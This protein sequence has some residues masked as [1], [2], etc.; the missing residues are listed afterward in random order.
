MSDIGRYEREFVNTLAEA[1]YGAMRCPAS[2]GGVDRELPD[3]LV[4]R[5]R[6]APRECIGDVG[7]TEQATIG[8]DGTPY[9]TLAEVWAVEHKSGKATTL[10]VESGDEDERGEVEELEQF[11]EWFGARPLLAARFKRQNTDR[12]HYLVP[13]ENARM[14]DGGNYGLPECD[15]EDRAVAVVNSTTGEV[16]YL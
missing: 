12:R 4:S 9:G 14:T 11:A 15:I 16:S 13:P 6:A 7:L 3:V 2:G 1:G 8:N 5:P 10:Y